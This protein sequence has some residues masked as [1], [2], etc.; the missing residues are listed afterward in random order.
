MSVIM[1]ATKLSKGSLYVHFDN[2]DVLAGAA[3]D[4]NMDLLRK[5]VMA[6][7]GRQTNAKDKL[8]A[9]IDVF[10]DPMNPPVTGGCPMMNFGTEA[11]DTERPGWLDHGLY[12]CP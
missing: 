4:H 5:K 10:I 12:L 7:V 2:K 8:F 3:V 1:G 6:A 9:Y 11:D